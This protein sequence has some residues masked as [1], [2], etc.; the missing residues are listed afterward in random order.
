[1]LTW[2][3]KHDP[4]CNYPMILLILHSRIRKFA[5][6][7]INTKWHRKSFSTSTNFK[8]NLKFCVW[9]TNPYDNHVGSL[10]YLQQWNSGFNFD[11]L[12]KCETALPGQIVFATF[13]S[14]GFLNQKIIIIV[15]V[16]VRKVQILNWGSS[17]S[18]MEIFL[19]AST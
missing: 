18:V 19:S 6:V 11:K 12:C 10:C 3:N 15:S 8:N 14:C 17:D 16:F 7:F 5:T 1:M 2:M 4:G 9:C 13:V